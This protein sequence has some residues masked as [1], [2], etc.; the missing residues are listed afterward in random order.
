LDLL[1]GDMPGA[2][3]MFAGID[4]SWN[5]VRAPHIGEMVKQAEAAF[6]HENPAASV[7][8]LV[9]IRSGILQ[10]DDSVWKERKL[11]EVD[12]IIEQCMGL[13]TEVLAED[14]WAS[15]G[16]SISLDFEVTNRSDQ[17]LVLT[18]VRFDGTELLESPSECGHNTPV[19]WSGR[20]F[21][22][23]ELTYTSPYWLAKEWSEGMYTVDNQKLRGLPENPR[24]LGAT[25]TFEI[26][27]QT[28]SI[29]KPVVYKRTD[30]VKGEVYRPFEIVPPAFV[31]LSDD[32]IIF[33]DQRE[34]PVEVRVKSATDHVQGTLRIAVAEGWTIT[35]EQAEISLEKKGDEQSV[36]FHLLPPAEQQIASI[37]AELILDETVVDMSLAEISYDHIPHQTILQPARSKVVK[38][39]LKR[40][41]DHIGY[42][43]GAGDEV[44]ASLEQVGYD[45]DLLNENQ[46]DLALL[47]RYDAIILGVRTYNTSERIRFIQPALFQYVEQG[48]TLVTQYNTSRGLQAGSVA[49]LPL[50]LS[51]DR[52][53]DETAKVDVLAP[54]HPVMHYP[55][56]ITAADFDGWVQERGLYF[57]NQWD[58]AFTP[59]L[60]MHDPGEDPT[61]G[62]LLIA[63]YG[64][65]HFVYTGLSWF[66]QLPA[67]VPGAFR[68]FTNL[69]SLG[70]PSRS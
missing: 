50:E 67:G 29:F 18:S 64:K 9:K 19:A 57:P 22:P 25:F 69:I 53:T 45:V 3:D 70:Q 8:L 62:S 54:D 21:L 12:L 36:T 15:P 49:P 5:R 60:R 35:P 13:F 68:L 28:F 31:N 14:Y 16:D 39:N 11:A 10:L 43:M 17:P 65:G 33:A 61:D 27:G 4:I 58:E 42:I 55:N 59:V 63:P 51:R 66:R 32:V 44:P 34:R 24:E 52:V 37:N 48:G 47:Q 1:K 23:K 56:Q 6:Q 38:V 41:G 2:N 20:V 46:V 40:A 7:H 26:N 30:P